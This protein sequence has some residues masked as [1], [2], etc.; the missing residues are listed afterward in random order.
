VKAP[1]LL[2][3]AHLGPTIAVTVVAGL[4]ALSAGLDPSRQLLVVL[5]VL[6]GQLTIGWSND[7]LDVRRDRQVERADKPLATGELRDSTV[8]AALAASGAA[9]VVLSLA[10]GWRGGLCHLG[11]GVGAGLAY[12]LGLKGT[13]WS[14]LPYAVA[15]AALPAVVTLA[16]S[17]PELPPWTVVLAGG[18]LGVGAHFVNVLPDLDDDAATGV[19]GLPHRLGARVS[20]RLAT[21]VLVLGS[22]TVVLGRAGGPEVWGWV[23][24]VV[25]LL[26]AV[27]AVLG[28]GQTPFRAAMAIALVNVAMLT[29]P[30]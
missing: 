18:L 11:P 25:T 6:A 28:R 9:C 7:L 17:P 8:R 26:L 14:W 10:L 27:A 20:Q 2:R 13:R 12:N 5:A 23:A 1:A 22:L 16:A 3:A 4:L 24:L 30:G 29:L 15:F 19:R 21:A